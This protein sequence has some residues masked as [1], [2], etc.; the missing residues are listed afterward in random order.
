MYQMHISQCTQTKTSETTLLGHG[1]VEYGLHCKFPLN[2]HIVIKTHSESLL[3]IGNNTSITHKSHKHAIV[4]LKRAIAEKNIPN[5]PCHSSQD[6]Q[7]IN[8]AVSLTLCLSFNHKV[9]RINLQ[10]TL[11][12]TD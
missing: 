1:T 9:Y 8:I 4:Y 11:Y 5:C 7:T 12:S 2:T 3:Q 10:D 6:A